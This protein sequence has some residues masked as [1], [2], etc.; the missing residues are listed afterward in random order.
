[1]GRPYSWDLRGRLV[2]A[3]TAT[4]RRSAA[5]LGVWI[6]T[7]IRWMVAVETT[8]RAVAHVQGR[9]RPS[10]CTRPFLGD[11]IDGQTDITLEEMRAC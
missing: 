7:A 11:L 4:S 6:A 10:I 1:M 9:P 3:A 8:G 5:R 2:D